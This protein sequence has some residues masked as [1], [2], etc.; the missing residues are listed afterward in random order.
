MPLPSLIAGAEHLG[1]ALTVRLSPV[2]LTS[3]DAVQLTRL[4]DDLRT[5]FR[6]E[7]VRLIVLDLTAVHSYGAM[8]LG[9]LICLNRE[10]RKQRQKLVVCDIPQGLLSLVRL[11]G[12]I[13]VC[14]TVHEALNRGRAAIARERV[15]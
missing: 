13:P 3:T 2:A 4:I 14:A 1:D 8:F 10:L 15:A 12:I 6:F 9:E 7:P 5:I 11:D